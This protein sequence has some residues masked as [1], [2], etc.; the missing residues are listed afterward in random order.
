[1]IV[2]D[3]FLKKNYFLT[4]KENLI[5]INFP[6]YFNN[7]INYNGD[8]FFQFTHI[9]YTDSKINSNFY[10]ILNFLLEK[11]NPYIL[12]R[13]KVNLLTRTNKIIEYGFHT[14]FTNK[15]AKITTGIFYI[16]TNNGYTLFKKNN[17]KIKSVENRYVEFDS[18]QEHM[19]TSCTD[20][21]IRIVIN[22]NYIKNNK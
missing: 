8:N 2:K 3:N 12:I 15:N 21:K 9:F 5:N 22:L 18:N 20:E 1:M 19:G 13:I 11:I 17:K 7:G 14:D 4:I 6:W 10:N 16:N